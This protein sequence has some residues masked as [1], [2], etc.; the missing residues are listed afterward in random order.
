MIGFPLLSLSLPPSLGLSRKFLPRCDLSLA[1]FLSVHLD[2]FVPL[3]TCHCVNYLP[4]AAIFLTARF[5]AMAV[6]SDCLITSKGKLVA[7]SATPSPEAYL[8]T[9]SSKLIPVPPRQM[10]ARY[11]ALT[12]ALAGISSFGSDL[13]NLFSCPSARLSARHFAL[14]F[15]P[16]RDMPSGR[17]S[18]GPSPLF[19]SPVGCFG[20]NDPP[21]R[22]AI[23]MIWLSLKAELNHLSFGVVGTLFGRIFVRSFYLCDCAEI[24]LALVC[25]AVI[26]AREVKGV[27]RQEMRAMEGKIKRSH[28]GATIALSAHLFF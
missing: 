7:L 26:G 21:H 25:M 15:L 24:A 19:A 1:S 27:E 23:F 6:N 11:G 17:F 14:Q 28:M 2:L 10:P 13:P 16:L 22:R 3:K 8:L 5:R 9:I 20:P 12:G 4:C 18:A